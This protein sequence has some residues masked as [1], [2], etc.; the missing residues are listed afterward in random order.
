MTEANEEM[1][2][3][4]GSVDRGKHGP[5]S[6][7]VPPDIAK[8]ACQRRAAAAARQ[9]LGWNPQE[10]TNT[11]LNSFMGEISQFVVQLYILAALGFVV[12][13]AAFPPK[14]TGKGGENSTKLTKSKTHSGDHIKG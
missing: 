3:A 12:R 7:T 13:T 10:F 9:K 1:Q 14:L 11:K 2:E 8:C 6:S 5:Y 4:T